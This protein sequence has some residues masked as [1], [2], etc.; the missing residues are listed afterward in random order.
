MLI[1]DLYSKVHA[2]YLEWYRIY[3]TIEVAIPIL[4]CCAVFIE[5]DFRLNCYFFCIFFLILI[6][7]LIIILSN[8]HPSDRNFIHQLLNNCNTQVIRNLFQILLNSIDFEQ[9]KLNRI[10]TIRNGYNLELDR[11]R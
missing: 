9:S 7:I 10:L 1:D 11:L 8:R 2:T 4:D 5:Q 6:M 3:S